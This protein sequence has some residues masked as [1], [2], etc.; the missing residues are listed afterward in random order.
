MVSASEAI[1]GRQDPLVVSRRHLIFD[2][3]LTGEPSGSEVAYVAMGCFWG[4][5]RVFYRLEGVL[6]T[7][8]GYQG[9]FTQ[10]PTYEEVCTGLTGHAE[11]VKVVF[12]PARMS[13]EAVLARF[14][15]NHDP[16]QGYRQG[17]DVGTQYRS[18]IYVLDAVQERTARHVARLYE[19]RLRAAGFG[20]LTTEIA[21]AGEFFL[22]EEYHQQYLEANPHGYCGL[23]GTG[24]SCPV[25]VAGI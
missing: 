5:E 1:A 6:C 25:G 10:N 23:G 3:P 9:G 21:L 7:A 24:L 11:V 16:T 22:A 2:V 19:E 14:F 20:P 8:V 4:A 12:D 13:Y 15:E 17:A 18:A